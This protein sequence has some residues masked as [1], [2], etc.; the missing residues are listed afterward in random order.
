MF[1][2]KIKRS[3]VQEMNKY[4]SQLMVKHA[5]Q[6]SLKPDLV[7]WAAWEFNVGSK[8]N[9]VPT[10]E[11]LRTKSSYSISWPTNNPCICTW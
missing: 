3:P 9:I 7:L 1:L 6:F 10:L 8:E 11:K 5:P 2:I 4:K